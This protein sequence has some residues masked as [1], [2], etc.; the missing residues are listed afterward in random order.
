MQ[1]DFWGPSLWNVLHTMSAN[2]P[3]GRTDDTAPLQFLYSLADMMPC[4]YCRESYAVFIKYLPPEK[5]VLDG[6]QG[7][8]YWVY[9]LHNLVNWKLKKPTPYPSFLDVVLKYEAHRHS[10][11]ST[12][13]PTEWAQQTQVR[14]RDVTRQCIR[15][16]M[17]D[18]SHS[19]KDWKKMKTDLSKGSL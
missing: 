11:P 9:V 6:R 5:Y 8:M 7:F 17:N 12:P 15:Q 14:Y 1:V 10:G 16:F 13:D 3:L 18:F 19:G 2:A 4:K